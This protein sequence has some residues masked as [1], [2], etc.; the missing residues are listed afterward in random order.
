MLDSI[1][2]RDIEGPP[3][4]VPTFTNIEVP[5]KEDTP[6]QPII[7]RYESLEPEPVP[8]VPREHL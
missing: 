7:Q 8:Y 1:N 6:P 4:R 5:K 2:D 3:L